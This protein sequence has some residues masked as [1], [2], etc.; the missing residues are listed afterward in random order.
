[1]VLKK[2]LESPL[3]SKKMQ[4]VN[5]KGNQPWIFIRRIEANTEGKAL[6]LWS[7]DSKSGLTGKDPDA[8]ED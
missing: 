1:M 6:I 7:S 8:G 2:I 4:P 3:V 5:P